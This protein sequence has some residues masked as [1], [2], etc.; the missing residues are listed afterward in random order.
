VASGDYWNP[1]ADLVDQL[2][3]PGAFISSYTLNNVYFNDTTIGGVFQSTPASIS[4]IEDVAEMVFCAGGGAGK[5]TYSYGPASD[6]GAGGPEQL[7]ANADQVANEW[8]VYGETMPPG[9]LA[10]YTESQVQYPQ[11]SSSN[12]GAFI[13]RFSGGTNCAFFDGHSKFMLISKLARVYPCPAGF[14]DS[15]NS[16]FGWP[17]Q[18]MCAAGGVMPYFTTQADTFLK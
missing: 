3:P 9:G 13:G 16:A 11:L 8:A 12:Q 18:D 7:Y 4:Q 15:G 14:S 6:Y 17:G 2:Q 1:S 10:Y 5:N